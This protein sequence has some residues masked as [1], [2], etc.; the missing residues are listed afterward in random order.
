MTRHTKEREL[1]PEVDNTE[2]WEVDSDTVDECADD[3]W[4]ANVFRNWVVC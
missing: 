2:E 3:T 1:R 4:R